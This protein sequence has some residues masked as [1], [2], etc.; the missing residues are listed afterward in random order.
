MRRPALGAK[1][2]RA[3]DR[4]GRATDL[5]DMGTNQHWLSAVVTGASSGIGAAFARALPPSTGMLLAGRDGARL[6]ATAASVG[7]PG[8]AVATLVG[9]LTLP[10]DVAALAARADALAVDLLIV[11]AGFGRFGRVVDNRADD[12]LGMIDLN[13]RASVDLVHRLLPGMLTRA[14]ADRRRAGLILV[15]SVLAWLPMA[16]FATYAA[17]KA[18]ERHWGEALAEE[19]RGEPIDVT[20]LCPGPTTTRFWARSGRLGPQPGAG[21]PDHVARVGLD[22]LGRHTVVVAGAANRLSVGVARAL[23]DRLLRRALAAVADRV[24]RRG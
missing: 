6:A 7:A 3:V 4:P 8:R 19:L 9:D 12:E 21:D 15:S 11:N 23:P 14:R 18:F 22:A 24:A 1:R 17:T 16:R 10:A 5:E 13:V 2:S 20:V